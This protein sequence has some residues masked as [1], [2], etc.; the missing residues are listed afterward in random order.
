MA[1]YSYAIYSNKVAMLC[2]TNTVILYWK[3]HLIRHREG[4]V[5]WLTHLKAG[6]GKILLNLILLLAIGTLGRHSS[7]ED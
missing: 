2:F 5:S 6:E 7:S 3:C 4:C 1:S